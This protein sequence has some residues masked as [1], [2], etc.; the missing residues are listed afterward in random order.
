MFAPRSRPVVRRSNAGPVVMIIVLA[1]LFAAHPSLKAK[2]GGAA[3]GGA[4]V[5][6][7][8]EVTSAVSWAKAQA[9]C[10]YVWGGTGPCGAGY[11]CSGLLYVAYAHAGVGIPRTSQGMW[12]GLRH[13]PLD[14]LKPGDLLLYHGYLASGESPP[15]HVVM[16]LGRGW[17]IQAYATGY[18]VA[19]SHGIPPGAWGAV[20]PT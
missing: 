10:P 12:A 19:V 1:L 14:Q 9:G 18:P 6:V 4:A 20:R 5:P 11:D 13:V 16:Y 7:A 15:G 17:I 3:T 2:T 8:A